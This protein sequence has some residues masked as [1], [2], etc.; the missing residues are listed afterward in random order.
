M[1]YHK[2]RWSAPQANT[3]LNDPIAHRR[4]VGQTIGFQWSAKGIADDDDPMAHRSSLL[5]KDH[6]WPRGGGPAAR[7]GQ[8]RRIARRRRASARPLEGSGLHATRP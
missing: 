7:R 8:E 4:A 5:R 6:A 3:N 2:N 1:A